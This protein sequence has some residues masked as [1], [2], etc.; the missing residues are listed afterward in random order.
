MLS[1]GAVAIAM[2]QHRVTIVQSA[3]SHTRNDGWLDVYTFMPFG[4]RLFLETHVPKAR[5]ASSDLLAIFPSS[6]AFHTPTEGMLQLPQKAF[7]EFTELTSW[8]Q[9]QCEDL[10]CK[11]I[12]SK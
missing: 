12:A 2:V 11:W 8:N 1:D 9:K 10:W 6:D 4:E 5:I 7:A 3:R